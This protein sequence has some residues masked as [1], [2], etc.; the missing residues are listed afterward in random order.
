MSVVWNHSLGGTDEVWVARYKVTCPMLHAKHADRRIEQCFY[1]SYLDDLPDPVQKAHFLR[2][3]LVERV[4]E[5]EAATII[6][7]A[8]QTPNAPRAVSIESDEDAPAVPDGVNT[9]LL[10]ECVKDLDQLGVQ[11]DVGAPNA[12]KALRDSGRHYGN[13]TIAAAVRARKAALAEVAI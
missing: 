1:G 8:P 6:A 7:N 11:Q 4:T 9:D 12:R 3:G 13:D 2:L 5:A 10:G